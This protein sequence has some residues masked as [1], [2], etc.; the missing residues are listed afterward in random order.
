PSIPHADG[1]RIQGCAVNGPALDARGDTVALAWYTEAD[2]DA[3]VQLSTSTDGGASWSDP[4]RVDLG[5]P[6]GR[7]DVAVL[8]DGGVAVV[9]LEGA[10]PDQ[11]DVMVRRIEDVPKYHTSVATVDA[12]RSSGIPQIVAAGDQALVAW[13]DA[14]EGV[15]ASLV[16][17]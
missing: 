16:S 9:W 7:V 2:G 14:D 5:E 13:T 6:I 11:A 12:G 8:E 1:W 4:V 3:R 10:G 15:R 17:L